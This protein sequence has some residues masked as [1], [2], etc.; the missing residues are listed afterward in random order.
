MEYDVPRG[1]L[2]VALSPPVRCKAGRR[3]WPWQ[4]AHWQARGRVTGRRDSSAP[5]F[6]VSTPAKFAM[7]ALKVLL[8]RR[9]PGHDRAAYPAVTFCA[10]VPKAR[11]SL[12]LVIMHGSRVTACSD[13]VMDGRLLGGPWAPHRPLLSGGSG[14]ARVVVCAIGLSAVVGRQQP[15]RCPTWAPEVAVCH[16]SEGDE[17]SFRSVAATRR[18]RSQIYPARFVTRRPPGSGLNR[19]R[20]GPPRPSFVCHEW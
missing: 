17:S 18:R 13:T 11:A 5:R 19:R 20:V 16:R 9:P 7:D 6:P 14:S 2:P 10:Q 12:L 4:Q 8:H 1:V 3:T 15:K